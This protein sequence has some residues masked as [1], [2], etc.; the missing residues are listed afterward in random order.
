MEIGR[1]YY[2]VR[3]ESGAYPP[4]L[5]DGGHVRLVVFTDHD[6]ALKRAQREA[7]HRGEDTVVG[8]MEGHEVHKLARDREVEYILVVDKEGNREVG[9]VDAE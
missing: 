4:V 6:E 9:V 1:T 3:T 7:E 2:V 8:H 5:G